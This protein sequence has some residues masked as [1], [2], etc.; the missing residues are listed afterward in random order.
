MKVLTL[1]NVNVGKSCFVKRFCEDRFVSKYIPTIGIDY[2]VKKVELQAQL[3]AKYRSA[4]PA[5]TTGSQKS[6]PAGVRVNF[7]DVSGAKESAEIRNE[8][9][10]A[11]QGI[12]L[13]YDVRQEDSFMALETWWE[14]VSRYVALT[15]GAKPSIGLSGSTTANTPAGKA[16]GNIGSA[17]PVVIVCASKIDGDGARLVS[18]ETGMAWA[19]SH[20]CAGYFETTATTGTSVADAMNALV[21]QVVARFVL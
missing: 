6:A 15:E 19:K 18:T 13:L 11:S 5:A 1:G 12:I 17:H 7:W 14:E 4:E 3:L 21:H 2:G 8:F 10:G 16:V 9:Y 20:H